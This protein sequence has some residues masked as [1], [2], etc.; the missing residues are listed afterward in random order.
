MYTH[1]ENISNTPRIPA[2][3]F[4]INPSFPH[5]APENLSSV[6]IS[7]F[8]F[9]IYTDHGVYCRV[10]MSLAVICRPARHEWTTQVYPLPLA[11]EEHSTAQ[12]DLCLFIHL[13]GEGFLGCF[14][15]G[16]ITKVYS[17]NA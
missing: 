11:G 8:P 5:P 13:S 4:R 9:V 6:L 17:V 15:F 7:L 3:P 10:F 14:P 1:T 2:C 16:E 12:T